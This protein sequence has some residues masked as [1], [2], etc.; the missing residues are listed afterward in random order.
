MSGTSMEIDERDMMKLIFSLKKNETNVDLSH[1]ELIT[2]LSDE[3]WDKLGQLKKMT[4]L[5]LPLSL[6]RIKERAFR[7]CD[8]LQDVN[9]ASLIS[10]QSIGTEAFY[11]CVC[12]SSDLIL[13]DSLQVIESYAFAHCGTLTKLSLPS[14]LL[15]IEEHAFYYCFRLQV[16]LRARSTGTS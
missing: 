5:Q 15:R 8:E 6:R 13:P 14:P 4:T 7:G 3:A 16:G 9:F 2:V 12:L 1:F 10:L 11:G